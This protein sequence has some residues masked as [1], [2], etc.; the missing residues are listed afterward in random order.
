[1]NKQ[2]RT[3]ISKLYK[4]EG[5][6]VFKEYSKNLAGLWWLKLLEGYNNPTISVVG[7]VTVLLLIG[8]TLTFCLLPSTKC[9]GHEC[10][11]HLFPNQYIL[12]L[13]VAV[14]HIKLVAVKLKG[15]ECTYKVFIKQYLEA[16]I[17][18]RLIK[19]CVTLLWLHF[20]PICEST[21]SVKSLLLYFVKRNV[22]GNYG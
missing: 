16:S 10:Y 21:G 9:P 6:K 5:D 18:C 7:T 11:Q 12:N 22:I 8:I 2:F 20:N 19:Y 13:S 1:M 14:E 17:A 4:I 15:V 3:A